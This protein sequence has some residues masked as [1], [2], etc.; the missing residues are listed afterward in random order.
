M[1][2]LGLYSKNLVFHLFLEFGKIEESSKSHIQKSK[3]LFVNWEKLG[4]I[5]S[6]RPVQKIPILNLCSKLWKIYVLS[7]TVESK[8]IYI[9]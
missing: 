6:L 1:C 7:F 4:S 8:V 9:K 3:N 2:N 5:Y